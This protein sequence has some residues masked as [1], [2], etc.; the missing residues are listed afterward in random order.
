MKEVKPFL[1]FNLNTLKI[2][3]GKN[4]LN[5]NYD[6]LVIGPE[7]DKRLSL[8]HVTIPKVLI[9][10]QKEK[11]NLETNFNLVIRLPINIV[12]FNRAIVNLS[13]KH[14]FDQNSL[15]KI[16]DYVLDKNERVL[17]Q[18][19]KRLKVTEK[20]IYFIEKLLAFQKTFK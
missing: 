13:Q 4:S 6:V 1:G 19:D 18:N 2:V 8:D 5:N 9:K 20:E 15:I 3:N 11:N 12:E 14:K 17:K 10:K 16:K 7:S